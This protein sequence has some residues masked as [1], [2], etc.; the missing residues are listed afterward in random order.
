[1]SDYDSHKYTAGAGKEGL[2]LSSV[3][4]QMVGHELQLGIRSSRNE[5]YDEKNQKVHI[6]HLTG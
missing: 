5:G 1:M 2:H 6:D 4:Q 3:S